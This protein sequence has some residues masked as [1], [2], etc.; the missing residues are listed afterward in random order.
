[1]GLL[2]VFVAVTLAFFSYRFDKKLYNPITL[3]CSI[4]LDF[5]HCYLLLV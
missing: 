3:F 2:T 5:I 4:C 1:M